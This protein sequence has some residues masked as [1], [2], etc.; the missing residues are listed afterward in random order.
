MKAKIKI[1]LGVIII[2]L[3]LGQLSLFD[4]LYPSTSDPDFWIKSH[5]A[6][7]Q[8]AWYRLGS[9]FLIFSYLGWIF[10]DV[11]KEFKR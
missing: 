1:I 8:I 9:T 3:F 7:V 6:M 4:I 2:T 10:Y 11:Y 5:Q